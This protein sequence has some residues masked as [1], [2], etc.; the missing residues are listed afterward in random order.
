MVRFIVYAERRAGNP[1]SSLEDKAHPVP[2]TVS[3]GDKEEHC[4]G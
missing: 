4:N 1:A 2:L 3:E